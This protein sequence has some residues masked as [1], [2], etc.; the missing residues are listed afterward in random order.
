MLCLTCRERHTSGT[1][2]DCDQCWP[3]VRDALDVARDAVRAQWVKPT[4]IEASVPAR[5]FEWNAFMVATAIRIEV[6]ATDGN[7][8]LQLPGVAALPDS[9]LATVGEMLECSVTRGTEVD[10]IL[11]TGYEGGDTT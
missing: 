2:H 6:A 1:R 8:L 10:T 9:V 11:V 4:L 7:M 3:L 5:M